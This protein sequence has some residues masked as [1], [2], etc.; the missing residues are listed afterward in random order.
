M[1]LIACIA[2]MAPL[3]LITGCHSQEK[4]KT[5]DAV[6][7]DLEKAGDKVEEGVEKAGEKIEEAG[8]K[9]EEGTK[10]EE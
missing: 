3:A 4:A 1:K 7:S 2:L 6:E 8:D 9:V 10:N 5:P